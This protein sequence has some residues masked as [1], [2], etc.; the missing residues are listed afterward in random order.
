MQNPTQILKRYAKFAYQD[1]IVT[2]GRIILVDEPLS[3]E[4]RAALKD[5]KTTDNQELLFL[6]GELLT[7][8]LEKLLEEVV[9]I[10]KDILFVFPGNGANYPRKLLQVQHGF[11]QASVHAKRFWEPGCD[12]IVTVGTIIP[13]RFL[14]TDVATVLVV[15]DVISS[16]LTLSKIYQ[17]NSWRFSR[18]KW[19]GAA[20]VSQIP[21]VKALS[22][23]SGYERIM[24]GCAIGKTN[25]GRVP[26]NSL[27]TLRVQ[28]D[29]AESYAQ[30]HFVDPRVFLS[31]IRQ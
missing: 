4:I 15:D 19:L 24:A 1:L 17:N 12:P 29:I 16:G 8:T 22:G 20:W 27:S 18:A 13:E 23:V 6:D 10:E 7:A 3:R 2:S 28:P 30:R 21:Q 26:I 31:L 14:I 25:G 5:L 9:E 11:A